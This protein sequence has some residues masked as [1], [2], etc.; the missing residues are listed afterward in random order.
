MEVEIEPFESFPELFRLSNFMFF[1][2]FTLFP[3][4]SILKT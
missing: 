4:N 2:H 3:V 1:I